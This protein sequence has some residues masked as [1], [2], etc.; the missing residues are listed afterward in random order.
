MRWIRMVPPRTEGNWGE[1][2]LFSNRCQVKL[3]L[4]LIEDKTACGYLTFR[5]LTLLMKKR[6]MRG[7]LRF[8]STAEALKE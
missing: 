7:D 8:Q 3:V 2:A 6:S 1:H 4:I 5:H